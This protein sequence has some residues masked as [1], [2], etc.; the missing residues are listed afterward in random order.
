[1]NENNYTNIIK[2]NVINTRYRDGKIDGYI[3][4]LHYT[5]EWIIDNIKRGNYIDI[6]KNLG[7]KKFNPEVYFMSKNPKYY[8]QLRNNGKLIKEIE[9]IENEINTNNL[10]YI[11][12]NQIKEV[13]DNIQNGDIICFTTNI[14]GL[15]YGHLGFA[16]RE[17][18]KLKLLHASTNSNKVIIDEE[19]HKYISKVKK[20][21]GITVIRVNYDKLYN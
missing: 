14:N 19:L 5:S 20:H 4:R 3:S 18:N 16:Y 17:N 1:M 11:P 9:S 15:A 12:K 8:K 6:T 2:E 10:Y 21:S 13:E 7:G